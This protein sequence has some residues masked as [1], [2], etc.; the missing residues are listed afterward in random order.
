MS[1]EE[2]CRKGRRLRRAQDGFR[3]ED[4]ALEAVL[5]TSTRRLCALQPEVLTRPRLGQGADFVTVAAS[6]RLSH[7]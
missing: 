7:E 2:L 1:D 3:R 4:L 5:A 6:E